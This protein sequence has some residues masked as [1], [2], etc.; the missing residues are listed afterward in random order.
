MRSSDDYL[1]NFFA[2]VGSGKADLDR[3]GEVS[4]I[5]AHWFAGVT[6]EDHQI[7]YDSFDTLV[8]AFWQCS[9]D[10]LPAEIEYSELL[11]LAERF[12]SSEEQ[13]AVQEFKSLTPA[14]TRITTTRAL[15]INLVALQRITNMAEASS[16]SRNAKM[17][18]EYPL[19][20]SSLARR[21]IWRS[22]ETPSEESIAIAKCAD[23]SV[24]EFVR[25]ATVRE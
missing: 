13:W 7:P 11:D 2:G 8:D 24:A 6:L 17:A 19:V 15:E 12:G 14:D 23:Q 21:L 22:Y 18:L 16:A 9:G 4:F 1:G 10:A 20:M 5:E 25:G 3:D